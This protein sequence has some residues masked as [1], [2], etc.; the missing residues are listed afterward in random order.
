MTNE[1]L[2]KLKKHIEDVLRLTKDNVMNKTLELSGL[3]DNV[4]RL[5]IKELKI[6]KTLEIEKDE[7]YG[8]LYHK[9]TKEFEYQL[10]TKYEV[11]N[12]IFKDKLFV[13][14]RLNIQDRELTVKY[15]EGVLDNIKNTSFQIKS[16]VDQLKIQQGII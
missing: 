9:Y 14:K 8:T 1:N 16:Y 10:D 12:Y 11:E 7:L 15:L 5:L 2:E 4:L 6:Y 13:Q 3:Y